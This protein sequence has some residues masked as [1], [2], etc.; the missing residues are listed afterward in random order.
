LR[1]DD[2]FGYIYDE[3]S[4]PYLVEEFVA[5]A[6]V[7]I[8][9]TPTSPATEHLDELHPALRSRVVIIDG[10][11][12]VGEQVA[13]FL[14]PI[15]DEFHFALRNSNR[16]LHF[17][18]TSDPALRNTIGELFYHLYDFLLG[19]E[20]R[21]QID[22]DIGKMQSTVRSLRALARNP[23][24]RTNLA[25][26]EGVL[27]TYRPVTITSLALK[28]AAT[29]NQV[30]RFRTFVEDTRYQAVSRDA[31]LLGV[32]EEADRAVTL[33]QRGLR[34]LVQHPLFK[35]VAG[36]ASKPI[37]KTTHLDV[38]TA[39]FVEALL[40]KRY[41][42][43]IVS[44]ASAY[45]RAEEIWRSQRPPFAESNKIVATIGN[46]WTEIGDY[47]QPSILDF[48]TRLNDGSSAPS[49]TR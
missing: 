17:T 1:R 45:E 38:D 22:V 35:S 5:S 18:S 28:S 14:E 13:A 37:S 16:E 34:R 7:E 47:P 42:P 8:A 3:S 46:G 49:N 30:E 43:P 33:I 6:A 9:I 26:L 25:T 12:R 10:D 39:S 29:D 31:G 15:G 44:L 32:P 11:Q 41:V 48:S 2:D 23:L 24:A 21:L 4:L 27:G 40:P 36:L 20:Y 19:A